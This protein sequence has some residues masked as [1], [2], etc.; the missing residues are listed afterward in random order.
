M[1]YLVLFFAI[2]LAI[3]LQATP[4]LIS[5]TYNGGANSGGTLIQY[6]AGHSGLSSYYSLHGTG[7]SGNSGN[8]DPYGSVIQAS[9]GNIYGMTYQDGTNHKGTIFQYNY[10]T[11]TYTVEVSFDSIS[12]YGPL[13]SLL[14]VSN[15]L[16]YGLTSRG[17]AYGGG[18][19]F[20]YAIGGNTVT[21]LA[22]L[23]AN[24]Q[25]YGSLIQASDGN[26]YGMTKYDGSNSS[27]TIFEFNLSNNTYAVK[28]SLPA[29]AQPS[30][31]L[32]EVGADTLYGLTFGDGTNKMGTIFR[33]I[34]ASNTYSICHTFDMETGGSPCS[35]LIHASDGLLYGTTP[36][37]GVF[38]DGVLFNYNVNTHIYTDIHDFNGKDGRNPLSSLY[39]AS[40][41]LLYGMTGSGGKYSLGNIFD[42]N[43]STTTLT[44]LVSFDGINGASPQFASITEYKEPPLSTGEDKRGMEIRS[45]NIYPNPTSGRLV[46]EQNT[47]GTAHLQVINMLG[48]TLKEFTMTGNKS[49]FD[50]SDLATGIYEV[51]ISDDKQIQ[52]TLKIIKE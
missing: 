18:T 15:G 23:P 5:M 7:Q 13:G 10:S 4:K 11:N 6:T 22:D 2:F 40:D 26:L 46:V 32:L 35:S 41:G 44:S 29:G 19:I 43:I 48:R 50:I 49:E 3:H 34:P 21:K 1:K 14:E 20:S 45:I 38:H 47:V 42:Y 37:G 12:G 51:R 8:A 9:N 31:S 52:K 17:G 33:Y 28:Y 36:L 25:P 30:G 27:G 39:Q 16:L 24:A